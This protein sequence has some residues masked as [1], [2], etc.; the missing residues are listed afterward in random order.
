MSL[1]RRKRARAVE[2]LCGL[3]SR[4]RD[5]GGGITDIMTRIEE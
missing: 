3:V 4:R 1:V 5:D 2:L